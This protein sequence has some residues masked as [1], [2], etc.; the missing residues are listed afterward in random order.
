MNALTRCFLLLAALYA[1]SAMAGNYWGAFA[2]DPT[3]KDYGAA[4]DYSTPQEAGL[5]ALQACSRQHGSP[6]CRVIGTFANVCGALAIGDGGAGFSA[7]E[8]YQQE[9]LDECRRGGDRS[10]RIEVTK[11][12][13]AYEADIGG[14]VTLPGDVPGENTRAVHH[15]ASG[16][17]NSEW[18]HVSC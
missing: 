3:N 8:N 9:A 4:V 13:H 5:A 7:D 12:N 10:C 6:H 1:G 14:P 18:Q 17:Y 15:E 11:C 2:Y 16:C